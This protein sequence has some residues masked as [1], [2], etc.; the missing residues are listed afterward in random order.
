VALT[1]GF[2]QNHPIRIL[3]RKLASSRSYSGQAEGPGDRRRAPQRKKIIMS[4]IHTTDSDGN[5]MVLSLH[6]YSEAPALGHTW[7][8]ADPAARIYPDI[9]RPADQPR[10]DPRQ[11]R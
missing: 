10:R 6:E 11:V 8:I 7:D 1:S 5:P 9:D 3:A 2:R 4:V